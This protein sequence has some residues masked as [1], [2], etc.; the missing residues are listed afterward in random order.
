MLVRRLQQHTRHEFTAY[1]LKMNVHHDP[2]LE[3]SEGK[4]GR[5]FERGFMD[6]PMVLG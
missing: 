1:E 3:S 4:A 6:H 5:N 2:I